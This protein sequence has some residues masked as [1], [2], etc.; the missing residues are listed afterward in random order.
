MKPV[1]PLDLVVA[2][3]GLR[4][5]GR[6]FP[7][8]V[9]QGGVTSNKLEGDL[10][11]PSGTHRIAGML[12]RPDRLTPPQ[13]WAMPL[14]PGDLWCDDP[15]SESYNQLARAPLSAS[16]ET[17]RR[18][19]PLYNLILITNWN[20]PNAVPGRGSAI[21]LHAWRRPGFPTAGCIGL[22]PDH[23]LWIAARIGLGTQV[24]VRPY[25]YSRAPKMAEPTRMCVAP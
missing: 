14:M 5:R 15:T 7:C 23:L 21:F 12:Y 18:A 3:V 10:A 25:P 2:P 13:D 20:W 16:H 4:Y 11:T 9:G 22:R 19:D 8:V 6:R 1:S 24:V 17:L